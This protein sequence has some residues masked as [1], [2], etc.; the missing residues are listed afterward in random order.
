MMN[1]LVIAHLLESKDPKKI[2]R[3]LNVLSVKSFNEPNQ[4]DNNTFPNPHHLDSNPQLVLSLG[5]FIEA[6]N[7]S[8]SLLVVTDSDECKEKLYANFVNNL[9]NMDWSTET[10]QG[11]LNNRAL[12][13]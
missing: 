10:L 5:S 8:S 3:A 6:V 7:P 2:I 1:Y 11:I 12:E 13:V 9:S 4:S